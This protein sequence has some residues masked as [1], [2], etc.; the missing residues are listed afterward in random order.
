VAVLSETNKKGKGGVYL[1]D[2][3]HFWSEVEGKG[4]NVGV[5]FVIN[6]EYKIT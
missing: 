1:E 4:A 5:S 3:I 2:F 6:K